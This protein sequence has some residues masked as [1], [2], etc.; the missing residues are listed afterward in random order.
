MNSA[1]Y[2]YLD[3]I[4][5]FCSDQ[6]TGFATLDKLNKIQ[7]L[8]NQSEALNMIQIVNNQ[9]EA[10]FDKCIARMACVRA[11]KVFSKDR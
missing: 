8:N 3:N 4:Y 6:L 10:S 9:R 2:F 1:A 7:F 5:H 11:R